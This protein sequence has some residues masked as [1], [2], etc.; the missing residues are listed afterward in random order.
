M[1]SIIV[2]TPRE[3]IELVCQ[4]L[5][6]AV[7]DGDI[8][9]IAK[10]LSQDFTMKPLD[11]DEF[12]RRLTNTLTQVRVDQVRL[13]LINVEFLS[14]HHAFA[15]L[16]AS[17]HIRTTEGFF[18]TIPSRWVLSFQARGADWLVSG[19]ESATTPFSGNSRS[20]DWLR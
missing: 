3:R 17:S 20:I 6:Q 19:I 9:E 4:D 8:E 14:E 7:D 10:R 5:G 18:G 16:N 2:V 13:R 1:L 15:T 11:R 12:I